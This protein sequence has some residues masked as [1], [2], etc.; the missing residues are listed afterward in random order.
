MQCIQCEI[1]FNNGRTESVVHVPG[2][3]LVHRFS[4]DFALHF[5][6]CLFRWRNMRDFVAKRT[7]RLFD[8]YL[9]EKGA[10]GCVGPLFCYVY[11]T[12]EPV[13]GSNSQHGASH[14]YPL[15]PWERL[16]CFEHHTVK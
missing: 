16:V 6:G 7:S 2:I 14:P 13:K 4:L 3:Q 11:F 1:H 10:S 12:F 9:Q 5:V 8:Q 15:W